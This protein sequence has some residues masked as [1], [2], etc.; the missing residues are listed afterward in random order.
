MT[1]VYSKFHYL[2]PYNLKGIEKNKRYK[3]IKQDINNKKK[4][5]KRIYKEYLRDM[6]ELIDWYKN[7]KPGLVGMI[8]GMVAGLATVT[9]ASGYIGPLGGLILGISSGIVC[10][11]FVG[12]VKVSLKIDD[13]LDVFAVHGIGGILGALLCGLLATEG[14]GGLGIEST[15]WEQTKIQIIGIQ[16]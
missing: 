13:S 10:Y 15:A 1:L 11:W 7:G 4:I 12:F 8:T 2:N 16:Q 3:F 5:V 6:N 14:F 9:P